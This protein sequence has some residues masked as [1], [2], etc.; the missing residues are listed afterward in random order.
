MIFRSRIAMGVAAVFAAA[1]LAACGGGGEATKDDLRDK[2]REENAPEAS[3]D[4]IT[5]EVFKVLSPSE[6]R[7]LIDA[8]AE[9]DATDKEAN[10]LRSAVSTCMTGAAPTTT[11]T[12]PSGTVDDGGAVPGVGTDDDDDDD[13]DTDT[14]D[15]DDTD[16]DDDTGTDDDTDTDDDDD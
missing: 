12:Q 4:C 16:T 7:H 1:G 11:G 3:V 8:D 14:D 9:S 15:D 10:A 2:L 5:D 13:D 6:V